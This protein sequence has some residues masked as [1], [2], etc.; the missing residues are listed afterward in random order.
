LRYRGIL[1]LGFFRFH[2]AV[3]DGGVDGLFRFQSVIYENGIFRFH[4]VIWFHDAMSDGGVDGVF[5][6]QGAMYDGSIVRFHDV[7]LRLYLGRV[8]MK[9]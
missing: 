7:V 9:G 2:D 8:L 4:D 1:V 3:S 5:R 6:F